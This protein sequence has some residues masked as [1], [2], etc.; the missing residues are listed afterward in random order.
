MKPLLNI[1]Y[2]FKNVLF[3]SLSAF[4]IRR[5]L[6]AISVSLEKTSCSQLAVVD[7]S[8]LRFLS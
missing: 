1:K 8:I 3:T 5:P 4:V 2:V 6:F 7:V